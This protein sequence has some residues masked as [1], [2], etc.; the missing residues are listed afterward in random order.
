MSELVRMS[1]S[2]E[3]ALYKRLEGLIKE[4]RYTNRSEFVRDM[5][6]EQLVGRQWKAGTRALGT[7]TLVYNH[8][9]RRLGEKLT[10]VQHHHH[11]EI[12]ASTHVH[13]DHDLCAEVIIIR[14]AAGEIRRIAD[15]L[16]QQK[17]VL[18][19]SLSMSTTGKNLA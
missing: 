1:F 9:R 5:I 16:R 19:A 10:K 6:R 15:E 13:L 2:I 11:E 17:G 18:H 7:V 8:H 14:G 3:K 4:S 12:L